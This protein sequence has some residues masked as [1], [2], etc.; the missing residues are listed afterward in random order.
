MPEPS[1]SPSKGP[2]R[3]S[4]LAAGLVGAGLA[5]TGCAPSGRS[6]AVSFYQSKPEV[7]GYFDELLARFRDERPGIR[8][9][10]DVTTDLSA[11]FARSA[12]PDLGCSNYNF[13]IARFVEHGALSDLGDMPEADRVNPDLLPLIGLT[14]SYPG[15]TSVL[16]Y[17]LMVAGVLYNRE[18]FDRHGLEVP[19]T[20][21]ELLDVCEA[22]AG[23]GVTPIYAT[24]TEPWTI[25]QGLFDYTA[26]GMV[27]VTAFFQALAE[28]GADTGPDSPVSFRNQFREPVER[29]LTLTRYVNPD[30]ANKG[31]GD[32]NLAFARGEA[33]MYFQGPWALTE[34]A[35]TS[36]ELDVGVFPLPM[37]EDPADRKV[38]VNVDLAL[39]VP[40]MS[41]RQEAARELVSFLLQPDVVD[42][43]N[44][45]NLGFGVTT[46]APPVTH[47]ALVEVQPYYDAAQFYLG[48]SQLVPESIPL[49]N[50]VQSLVTGADPD[51]VLRTLDAD[52]ARLARRS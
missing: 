7:I 6:A 9:A 17:S 26:G 19:T 28:Q 8:V 34:I 20:W 40:E 18:I 45:D 35:K 44:A 52:W 32:G 10:H 13:E 15:R 47:P 50:Y 31:Y 14:A 33:A 42:T 16:P 21:S 11:G 23:A 49:H 37:T 3:R 30:A 38:R 1:P 22:L 51:T 2:S 12:P 4:F 41:P 29:M 24:Y 27:D 43:Y 5:L 36:P 48:P 46:D 39:W 25:G